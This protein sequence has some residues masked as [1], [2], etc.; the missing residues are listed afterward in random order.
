MIYF[1]NAATTPPLLATE[2]APLGNPSSP[3]ALGIAAERL[4]TGARETI[5]G[6]LD[7]GFTI[8]TH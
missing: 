1:D 6:I 5:G 2:E 3:H 4:L 7:L 8:C